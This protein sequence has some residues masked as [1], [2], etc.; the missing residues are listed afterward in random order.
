MNNFKKLIKFKNI[1]LEKG[2]K[3]TFYFSFNYAFSKF[4]GLNIKISR[5]KLGD[6]V[7]KKVFLA[8]QSNILKKVI[9]FLIQCLLKKHSTNI[10]KLIIGTQTVENN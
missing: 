6:K 10:M 5:N 3:K 8:V 1:L 9:I 4:L 2:F 7:S